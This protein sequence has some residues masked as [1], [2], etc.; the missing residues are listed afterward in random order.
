MKLTVR[1]RPGTPP[2][3]PLAPDSVEVLLDD[4]PLEGLVRL[5]LNV[6]ADSLVLARLVVEPHGIE[7]DGEVVAEILARLDH[8][9]KHEG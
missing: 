5:E 9:P 4:R 3:L 8:L 6:S 2:G 1:Q 7:V